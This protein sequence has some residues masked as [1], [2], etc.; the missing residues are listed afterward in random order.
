MTWLHTL[1]IPTAQDSYSAIAAIQ[2]AAGT[3]G[4]TVQ[5]GLIY[6]DVIYGVLESPTVAGSGVA[7]YGR[8]NVFHCCYLVEITG[9]LFFICIIWFDVATLFF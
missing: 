1:L 7:I 3:L 6:Q 5:C 2:A 8:N 4:A 9:T